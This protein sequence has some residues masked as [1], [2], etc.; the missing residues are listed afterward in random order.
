M[1]LVVPDFDFGCNLSFSNCVISAVDICNKL[2]VPDIN[3]GVGPD[4]IL[5]IVLKNCAPVLVPHLAVHFRSLLAAGI[6]LAILKCSFVVPIFKQGEKADIRN[7][8]PIIIQ[9]WSCLK[10]H[11]ALIWGPFSSFYL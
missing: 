11:R 8:R 2:E 9:P 7:Y 6:F 3:K 10:C 1:T 5:H 4:D